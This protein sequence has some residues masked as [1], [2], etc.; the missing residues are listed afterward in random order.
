MIVIGLPDGQ[1]YDRLSKISL[2][3]FPNLSRVWT[4]V[5]CRPD[6][7]TFVARNFHIKASPVQ[8]RGMVVR[9]VDLM[10]ARL[11]HEDLRSD[12]WILN[13]ILALCMSASGRECTSSKRLQRSS[14]ICVLER[15]PIAGRTLSVVRMCC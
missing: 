10:L 11:D 13:A 9:K 2:K 1:L 15:D 4:V 5:P 6:D 7:R 8:T 3:F 12:V 14:H